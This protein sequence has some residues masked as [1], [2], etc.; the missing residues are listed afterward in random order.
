MTLAGEIAL[1]EIAAARLA[2]RGVTLMAWRARRG[3]DCLATAC[4]SWCVR[5]G[6]SPR[7][8]ARSLDPGVGGH[9]RHAGAIVST[10]DRA[11]PSAEL[12]QVGKR[13]LDEIERTVVGKRSSS[14]GPPRRLLH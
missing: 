13:V 8:E 14:C 3:S 12:A 1:V 6:R 2:A 5:V 7:T 11:L 10:G 9:A 4:G